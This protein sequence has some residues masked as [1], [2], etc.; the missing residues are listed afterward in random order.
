MGILN[1]A[2]TSGANDAIVKEVTGLDDISDGS[3]GFRGIRDVEES[4]VHGGIELLA[5]RDVL[6]EGVLLASLHEFGSGH[7]HTFVET[8]QLLVGGVLCDEFSW[9]AVEGPLEVVDVDDQILG[10]RLKCILL[11][12]LHVTQVDLAH[13]VDVREESKVLGLKILLNLLQLCVGSLEL[14]DLRLQLRHVSIPI[15]VAVTVSISLLG[16]F[17]ILLLLLL[18]SSLGLLRSGCLSAEGLNAKE[19]RKSA[20]GVDDA[21]VRSCSRGHLWSSSNG[22]ASSTQ[23]S[24]RSHRKTSS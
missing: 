23:H 4:H 10:K 24:K 9:N 19:R 3:M 1:D 22:A 17:L 16:S 7:L 12:L 15:S 8:L 2:D 14:R 11:R 13:V 20:I 5:K 21:S 6:F 18:G